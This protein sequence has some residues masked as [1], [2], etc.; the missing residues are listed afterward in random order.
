MDFSFFGSA[1]AVCEAIGHRLLFNYY[2]DQKQKYILT[3]CF[4]LHSQSLGS[5]RHG[6]QQE[7][8]D[9]TGRAVRQNILLRYHGAR[10]FLLFNWQYLP[11]FIGGVRERVILSKIFYPRHRRGNDPCFVDALPSDLVEYCASS[12]HFWIMCNFRSSVARRSE[13][14][15]ERVFETWGSNCLLYYRTVLFFSPPFGFLLFV[16]LLANIFFEWVLANMWP[17]HITVRTDLGS[18]RFTS[19]SFGPRS[20]LLFLE[21]PI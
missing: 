13:I 12:S 17:S 9:I 7:D 2:G 14:L 8:Q 18:K 21:M 3:V 11:Q 15:N 10:V 19:T 4:L 1:L 5:S 16:C 6:K 20:T